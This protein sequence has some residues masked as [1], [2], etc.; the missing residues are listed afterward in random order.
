MPFA[1]VLVGAVFLAVA[2]A[3][4]ISTMRSSADASRRAQALVANLEATVHQQAALELQ[5]IASGSL[6]SEQAAQLQATRNRAGEIIDALALD[7][8][9][10][11]GLPAVR[12]A[13]DG[14]R[15]ALEEE[16]AAL[17]GGDLEMAAAIEAAS[18]APAREA[19]LRIRQAT[20]T[21][22]GDAAQD[23]TVAADI[24]TLSALLSAA[25]LVSL[26]FRRWERTRRRNAF[27]NG[28][29]HGLRASEARF[30]GL[31]QH[32]SDLIAVVARDG[33]LTYVSPSAARVLE[34]SSAALEGTPISTIVHLDD[35]PRV[36][37]LLALPIEDIAGR[38]IEWRLR[39]GD[40][41]QTRE[42][43][44]TFE[45]VVSAVDPNYERS[46]IVLNSRDVTDRRELE[47]ALRQ[48]ASHDGLTGLANRA[49]LMD[50]LERALARAGRTGKRIGLLFIDLDDFK[51][52]NDSFGHAAGDAALVELAARV[53]R[54]VRADA[55]VARF[56]GDE[57]AVLL[58]DLDGPEQA[59]AVAKRI[60][61]AVRRPLIVSGTERRIVA[62]TGIALSS[63][64]LRGAGD[65]IA[66]ADRAMYL[67]KSA[68]G[69]QHV[70]ATP[71]VAGDSA[72]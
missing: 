47:E 71:G 22:L 46:A 63:D 3:S 43:W 36:D 33:S 53:R 68:G 60:H 61:D 48:R 70:M 6:S 12:A 62:S 4:T 17:G 2:A 35:R 27:L 5:A 25:I 58:E 42:R 56:G 44:R 13:L 38:T 23:S 49:V 64:E 31:V 55:V 57:F 8:R 7:E 45:S 19:F 52:V 14:Y 29:Q 9:A 66:A 16:L 69:A 20:E 32:S 72:A 15:S 26:L 54:V 40:G 50:A 51:V 1:V 24:G 18:V 10:S 21:R 37:E 59:V 34:C 65:L 30:R 11:F 39:I 67:A 28:E 41:R